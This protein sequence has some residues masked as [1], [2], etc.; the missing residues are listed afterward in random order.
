MRIWRNWQTR[1]VQVRVKVTSW[2]FES[3]YPHQIKEQSSIQ[4][5]LPIWR[6]V[7]V[8]MPGKPD[9]MGLSGLF[10]FSVSLAIHLASGPAL[11]MAAW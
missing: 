1:T 9:T 10:L 2:G 8:S 3:L 7:F 4:N 11:G 6:A 5:S